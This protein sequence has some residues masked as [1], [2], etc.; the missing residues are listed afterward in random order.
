MTWRILRMVAVFSAV[1][2]LLLGTGAVHALPI[3]AGM[4]EAPALPTTFVDTSLVPSTG[5]TIQ[6]GAGGDLQAALNSAQPGDVV[7]IAP[8]A[9]FV[10]NFT[11]PKKAGDGWI[12]VRSA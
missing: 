2:G 3:Q 5:Q 1:C 8:G 7:S 9:T 6:V 4:E 10:G 12:T 11:L